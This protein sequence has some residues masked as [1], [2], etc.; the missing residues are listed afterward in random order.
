MHIAR[1]DF[2]PGGFGWAFPKNSPYLKK[3]D[4][5]FQRLIESGIVEKWMDDLIQLSASASQDKEVDV[6]ALTEMEAVPRAF[7][8]YHLQG[9]FLFTVGGFLLALLVLFGEIVFVRFS[10][11][12]SGRLSPSTPS[13]TFK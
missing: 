7:T 10:Y 4:K 3:F 1:E 8:I 5:I 6:G 2:F 13:L 11:S 9:I 12:S